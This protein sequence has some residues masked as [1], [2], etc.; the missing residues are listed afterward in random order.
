M[1]AIITPWLIHLALAVAFL[2]TGAVFGY[3]YADNACQANQA[4]ALS[5][6][7]TEHN[8][9]AGIGQSVARETVRRTVKTEAVFNGIQQG[10]TSYAQN[11]PAD[12]C[13]LDADG[14]RLWRAANA[15]A[16][17][18][19]SSERDA[20]LPGA[21]DAAERR[22]DGPADQ[23]RRGD[24]GLSPVQGPAPGAGGLVGEDAR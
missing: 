7:V 18:L 8:E 2:G 11:H 1:S 3:R 15:N 9:A 16:D 21:T 5:V 19:P 22:D 10:V 6:V 17:A 13:R 24:E 4:K 14:L 12:D 23:S 20:A